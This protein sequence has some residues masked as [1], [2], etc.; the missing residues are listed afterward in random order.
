MLT[1]ILSIALAIAI[2]VMFA[3][4]FARDAYHRYEVSTRLNKIIDASDR[5]AFN[6][7]NGDAASFAKTLYERCQIEHGQGAATCERYHFA[8]K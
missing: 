1:R 3:A 5:V 6:Q 7:W 2:V 8:F 4:P